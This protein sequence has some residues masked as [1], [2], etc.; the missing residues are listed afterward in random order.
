MLKFLSLFSVLFLVA[1][2]SVYLKP[3]T[4]VPGT[5]VYASRGGNTMTRGI[6]EKLEEHGFTVN[7]GSLKDESSIDVDK[8]T[9]PKNTRYIVRVS[10]QAE[11]FMPYW[12]I[13]NGFWWWR[14]NVS[15]ADQKTGEEILSW[16]GRG[17]QNSSLRKLDRFLDELEIKE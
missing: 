7:V 12:C 2:N 6:K 8:F 3:N 9:V 4:M 10:E 13:F 5:T 11:T 1:C 17:C 16:R 14:F 15:I